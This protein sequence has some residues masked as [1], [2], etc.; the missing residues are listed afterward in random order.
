MKTPCSFFLG[1]LL[2]AAPTV[3]Q[4]QSGSGDG[5]G[6]SVNSGN[7][8]T[9]TINYYVGTGGAVA[10]PSTING[11]QVT[12]IGA[13]AFEFATS[14]TSVTIPDS[15]TT[16]GDSAFLSCSS[17][18][19]VTIPGSV[20]NIGD[21]AFE[22]C[23]SLTSVTI[24]NSVTTI[25]YDAFDNCPDLASV[26]IGANVG[27]IGI[28]AFSG[29][30]SLSSVTIPNSVTNISYNAFYGC[31]N[32]TSVATPGSVNIGSVFY[33]CPVMSVTINNGVSS[34]ASGQFADCEGLTNVTIPD[35]V[36]SIGNGAF[37]QCTSLTSVTIPDGVTSIGE[38]TFYFCTSLTNVTMPDTVTN[39][40]DEAFVGC[41]NLF[42]VIIPSSVI[43]IG[44]EAFEQCPGLTNN[45][46]FPNTLTTIGGLAF[47]GCESLTD[48]T[49]PNS[50]TYIGAGAFDYCP[51]LTS[52]TIPGCVTNFYQLFQVCPLTRVKIDNG[53]TSIG[54]EEFVLANLTGID[55][56][57]PASVTNI[58]QGAFQQT[59]VAGFMVDASNSTYSSVA[60]VLF[61]KSQT[62]LVEYPGGPDGSYTIPDSVTTIETNAFPFCD[63]SGVTIPNS[64][65]NIGGNGFYG[66]GNLSTVTIPA[67]VS[68]LAAVF[69]YCPLTSVT[70][71]SGVTTIDTNE[72]ADLTSLATVTIPASVTR[73]Q[74]NAFIGC[75]SLSSLYFEGNAPSVGKY[76]FSNDVI[77]AVYYSP[78]TAGWGATFAT[79]PA[80]DQYAYTT[81]ADKTLTIAGFAGPGP[82]GDIVLPS[83][84]GS[85]LVTS[86]QD[87]AFTGLS[88]TSLTIPASVTNFG[89]GAFQGCPTL[90][91]IIVETGN[92]EFSTINGVLFNKN[93]TTLIQYPQG[94]GGGYAIAMGVTSIE[95]NAF[96]ECSGLTGVTLPDSLTN[97]GDYA[98]ESCTNLSSVMLPDGVVSIGDGAFSGTS[99]ASITI[100]QSVTNIGSGA[101][102]TCFAL[103]AIT[104]EAPN[105]FYSS[106][107]GVLFDQPQTTLIQYPCGLSGSYTIPASVTNIEAGA[108]YGCAGLTGVTIFD[109][110]ASIGQSAFF[111]TSLASVAIPDSVTSIGADAFGQC[112]NLGS[113]MIP[114]SVTNLG[115]SSFY[116]CVGL[117]SVSIP[118]SITSIGAGAFENCISL[119][120]ATISTG[121]TLI[122][123]NAFNDCS[124]LGAVTIPES[125]T[126]IGDGA[127]SRSGL[128]SVTIP[129]S[130]TNI[131]S[132]AFSSCP[133]LEAITV[134]PLNGFYS[135]L[136]GVLL[137][138]S[139]STVIQYPCGLRASYT[140]PTSINSIGAA[141]FFSASLTN[142]TIDSGVTNIGYGAFENCRDLASITIPAS[143][144]MFGNYAFANCT[145]L[146]SVYF[147]GNDLTFPAGNSV[148]FDGDSGATF[149][150]LQGATFLETTRWP[151]KIAGFPT[152]AL[153]AI[154]FTANPTNGAI[155]LTVNFTSASVDSDGH[156]VT[157]WNWDFGDG[158]TSTSQN[159]THT[160]TNL[161]TISK[162]PFSV[163]LFETNSNGGLIAGAGAS[164]KASRLTENFTANPDAGAIPVTV[165]FTAAYDD[166][167]GHAVTHWN[168]SFGDGT[169]STNQ[170]PS[171]TYTNSGTFSLTLI[172]TNNMGETVFGAGP[173]SITANPAQENSGPLITNEPVSQ[174]NVAGGNVT[175]QVAATG[176]GTLAY[177]WLYDDRKVPGATNDTLTLKSVTTGN[178]GSYDVIVS[179]SYGFATSTVATVTVVA[180]GNPKL[181]I[182]SPTPGQNV[183][184]NNYIFTVTGKT[185]DKALVTNV[186]YQF[187]GGNWMPAAQGNS[188]SNWTA[189]VTLN[190]GANTISANAQDITGS[191]SPTVTASFKF[192]PSASLLVVVPPGENGTVTPNNNGKLLGLGTNFTLTASAGQ[193]W[194]FSNW[195][196]SG[197]GNFVSNDPILNF[198]MQ[199]NLVLTANFATNPFVAIKGAY[200]GLFYQTNANSPV[201]EQSSGF[202]T[203][204]IASGSKGAYS[205]VVKVDGGSYSFSS[206]FD[207]SGNS[208]T[209]IARKGKAPLLLTLHIDLNLDPPTDFMTGSVEATNWDG[210]SG[211]LADLDYFNGTTLKASNYAGKYTL[212]LPGSETPANLPGGYSAAEFVNNLAGNAVL[213]G[214]LADNTIL[215]SL[216]TPISKEGFVP[217]YYSHTPG[218]NVIFGWLHFTNDPTQTVAGDLTWF[219]LP[220]TSKVLYSNGFALQSNVIIGSLYAPVTTNILVTG[221]TLSIVDLAQGINLVYTNVSIVSNKLFYATTTT[222]QLTAA[223]ASTSGVISLSFRPTGAK[224]SLTAQGVI[225][226]NSPSEPLLKAAGWFVGANQ[227]GYF[228]LTQ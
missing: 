5:Y 209:N 121:V 39:V 135:S 51:N 125:V 66:C 2:L 176:A 169:T 108:F 146:A 183:A 189:S 25:G 138:H 103:T 212:V 143:A 215:S 22:D 31:S 132:G 214:S 10:I 116:G 167:V 161:A 20:T 119:T 151:S 221:G 172:A 191:I 85:Q 19:G 201:T 149:Y 12:G 195:V 82:G 71:D 73:I 107:D 97:I 7:P 35:S 102:I 29:C 154:T 223:I 84:I 32:L 4:G 170:N 91:A 44:A 55:V 83:K 136:D 225:L 163:V 62:T 38:G 188:W 155:P 106:L 69:G 122:E 17:L 144:T 50:V 145:N 190:P 3:V 40:G 96:E 137:D 74:S 164:I 42:N 109:G 99:L 134:E 206:A 181:T 227:T 187:N 77:T 93:L 59:V 61:N 160:Y 89:S 216:S 177:Q 200:N 174:T 180:P 126:S 45:L 127:F 173:A 75:T 15:V 139:Q 23:L 94:L 90:T 114:G 179:N 226:Q 81:N 141:A 80:E 197:S 18:T 185:T 194:L 72:F 117:T 86:I 210:P 178:A 8:N 56:S 30:T 192:F 13:A 60:G 111:A 100:P 207:L 41:T 57:I 162:F 64:V 11:L 110:V 46:A 184:T 152:E 33:K 63:L 205:G 26:A 92:P 49:I 16:I 14:L 98:F 24:P 6:Y 34:I 105:A 196:A 87:G 88:L 36:T 124:S 9:I 131:G 168:W 48:V 202:A 148:L 67:C 95:S 228:L 211:L 113:V 142:A 153:T 53:V 28:F 198:K 104:V 171:H 186:V 123:T 213:T 1:F 52:V 193:N 129:N 157:N 21:D 208:V 79:F 37:G 115:D 204:S 203:I 68:N 219:K 76:A 101:F 78:G 156:A 159:P 65:T 218:T 130:V 47:G 165:S 158:S 133:A 27:N 43:S 222:N 120:D 182:A 175:L 140:M 199:S 112:T 70:L 118:G 128:T 147:V 217:V 54:S 166:N 224:A 150:Y 58:A 220:A